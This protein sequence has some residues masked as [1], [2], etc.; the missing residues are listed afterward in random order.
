MALTGN[1]D[2]KKMLVKFEEIQI[3]QNELQA[4]QQRLQAE[5][6]QLL[7]ELAEKAYY[8][9]AQDVGISSGEIPLLVRPPQR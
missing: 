6:L 9:R 2:L 8:A 5:R 7:R 3:A 1:V 4:E